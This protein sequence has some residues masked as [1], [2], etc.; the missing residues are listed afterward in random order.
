MTMLPDDLAAHT[1]SGNLMLLTDH[2]IIGCRS[3]RD[4]PYRIE[5]IEDQMSRVASSLSPALHHRESAEVTCEGLRT[6][7]VHSQC[8]T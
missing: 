2:N 1:A 4:M 3:I 8:S 7:P 6:F 5:P